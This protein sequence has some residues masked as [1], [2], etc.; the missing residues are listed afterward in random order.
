MTGLSGIERLL[1]ID[2]R[3]ENFIVDLDQL[4][5][6]LGDVTARGRD[7]GNR[8]AD[9][10][11]FIMRKA[12]ARP[13]DRKAGDGLRP[14]LGVFTGNHR[15]HARKLLRLG[16]SMRLMRAWACGL[17]KMAANSM[18]GKATLSP[19]SALPVSNVASSMRAVSLPR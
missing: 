11:D 9:E 10:P 17:R 16:V 6:V 3:R 7:R 14:S 12:V 15:D 5:G 4:E 1:R 13:T 8:I 19:N 18:P 2:D